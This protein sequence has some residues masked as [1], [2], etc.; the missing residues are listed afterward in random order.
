MVAKHE[1]L[2]CACNNLKPKMETANY[3]DHAEDTFL[4]FPCRP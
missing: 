3:S 1:S 4:K 2:Q